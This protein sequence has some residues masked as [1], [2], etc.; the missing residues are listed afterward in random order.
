LP[1]RLFYLR[2]IYLFASEVN[3]ASGQ[4]RIGDLGFASVNGEVYSQNRNEA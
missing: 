2:T 1:G 4:S 3:R